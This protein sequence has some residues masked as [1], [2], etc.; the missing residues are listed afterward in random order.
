MTLEVKFHIEDE[1]FSIVKILTDM[2]I[3]DCSIEVPILIT[4]L[5]GFSLVISKTSEFFSKKK[6]KKSPLHDF[7]FSPLMRIGLK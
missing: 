6:K 4:N 5:Y 3:Y 1:P 2:Q 7:V